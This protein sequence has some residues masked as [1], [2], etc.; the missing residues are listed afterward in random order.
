MSQRL[1]IKVV[2][3]LL[4]MIYAKYLSFFDVNLRTDPINAV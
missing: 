3:C 1:K 4:R 2:D